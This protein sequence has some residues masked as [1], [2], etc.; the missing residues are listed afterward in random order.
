LKLLDCSAAKGLKISNAV[1]PDSMAS[2]DYEFTK[3]TE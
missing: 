2:D 3:Q 1:T